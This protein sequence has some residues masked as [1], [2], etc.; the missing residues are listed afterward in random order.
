MKDKIINYKENDIIYCD[1]I[2]G[3]HRVIKVYKQENK[4]DIL[5]TEYLYDDKYKRINLSFK[6]RE[7]TIDSWHCRLVDLDKLLK[8][9]QTKLDKATEVIM[10]LKMIKSNK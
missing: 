3:I 7:Y 8:F 9:E 2:K 10:K 4:P 5:I 6:D 1:K